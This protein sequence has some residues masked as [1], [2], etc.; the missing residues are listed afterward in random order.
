MYIYLILNLD[1]SFIFV[2]ECIYL[3]QHPYVLC[4]MSYV[5]CLMSYVFRLFKYRALI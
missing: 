5:L 4:L 1:I 2:L 3:F